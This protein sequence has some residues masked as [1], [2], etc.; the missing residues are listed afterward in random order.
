MRTLGTAAVLSALLGLSACGSQTGSSAP[1]GAECA[2]VGTVVAKADLDGR[3]QPST[4]R[5][6]PSASGACANRLLADGGVWADVGGLDLV[7]QQATVV[8][9]HGAGA[10]DL[11]L[12]SAKPH[13][14]GG[15]QPHLFGSGGATGLA[16][17]T[18]KGR[19]VVPF[20]ATDGG[21]PPMTATCTSDGGIAVL[22]AVAHEPPGV[23]LAW[24]VTE[25]K[26]TVKGGRAETTGSQ[27]VEEAAADPLLR[28][29]RPELF[30]GTLFANCD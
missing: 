9:L 18:S 6:T 10:P 8:H 30:D 15:W 21:A 5:L 13:P 22:T 14:R 29:E 27:M 25:T 1:E 4:V 26:Y 19:P 16:E 28:K 12:L 23:V 7:P 20:V 17:V 11:V 24:D 3:G 2:G